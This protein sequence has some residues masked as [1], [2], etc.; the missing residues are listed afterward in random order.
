[1]LR[2]I[3]GISYQVFLVQHIVIIVFYKFFNPDR[4]LISLLFAFVICFIIVFAASLLSIVTKWIL[5][6]KVFCRIDNF[7]ALNNG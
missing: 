4:L 7:F 5:K 3:G 1:L 6:Q 2:Y